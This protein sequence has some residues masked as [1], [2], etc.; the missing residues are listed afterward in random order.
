MRQFFKTTK[1]HYCFH[2]ELGDPQPKK[3]KCRKFISKEFAEGLIADGVADWLIT[4]PAG[5]PST[6]IVMRNIAS[7]TPRAQTIESAHIERYIDQ[8]WNIGNADFDD[9]EVL[10]H[11]DRYHDLEMESRLKLFGVVGLGLV[12]L[13]NSSDGYGDLSGEAGQVLVE[14]LVAEAD[15]MKLSIAQ[16]DTW[17]GRSV[18]MPLGGDQRTVGGVG[19]FVNK[20]D[21]RLDKL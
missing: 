17:I 4:F 16:N 13:K 2:Q 12:N 10:A 8:I 9:P 18:F 14:K 6:D 11:L 21:M 7:K 19:V 20:E 1:V 5:T 3:C 15:E